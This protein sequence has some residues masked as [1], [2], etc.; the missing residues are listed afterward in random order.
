MEC[1]VYRLYNTYI[2]TLG[3]MLQEASRGTLL[4]GGGLFTTLIMFW[5]EVFFCERVG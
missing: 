4:G 1:L 5:I 3:A 2:T